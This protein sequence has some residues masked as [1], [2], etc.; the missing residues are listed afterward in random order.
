MT[1]ILNMKQ[2]YPATTYDIDNMVDQIEYMTG[3][4]FEDLMNVWKGEV[5]QRRANKK[6]GEDSKDNIVSGDAV[7]LSNNKA[8]R[9]GFSRNKRK[10]I[11]LQEGNDWM[12]TPM[13]NSK[14]EVIEYESAMLQAGNP[15][16]MLFALP[17]IMATLENLQ[18]EKW[19]IDNGF[20]VKQS[21]IRDMEKEVMRQGGFSKFHEAQHYQFQ[22]YVNQWFLA[23]F[24]ADP[25]N[26][27][28]RGVDILTNPGGTLGLSHDLGTP[29][30]RFSYIMEFPKFFM[31]V[32]EELMSDPFYQDN[33]FL[34]KAELNP[35]KGIDFLMLREGRSASNAEVSQQ[36]I[37]FGKLPDHIIR[38]IELYSIIKDGFNYSKNGFFK[39]LGTGVFRQYSSFMDKTMNKIIAPHSDERNAFELDMRN[40]FL[41][42]IRTMPVQKGR[43]LLKRQNRGG[44]DPEWYIQKKK[45]GFQFMDVAVQNDEGVD[46][47]YRYWF[48]R[49][50]NPFRPGYDYKKEMFAKDQERDKKRRAQTSNQ[51]VYHNITLNEHFD[52]I[53]ARRNN[54]QSWLYLN[55]RFK[56][57][58]AVG[59]LIFFPNGMAG[60]VVW[61]ERNEVAYVINENES[62]NMTYVESDELP[63]TNRDAR[64]SFNRKAN[65]KA[66]TVMMGSVIERLQRK[67]PEVKVER[68]SNAWFNSKGKDNAF[69]FLGTDGTI[70]INKSK[71]DAQ[72]Y[73]HEYAHIWNIVLR[74]RNPE[75]YAELVSELYGSPIYNEVLKAYPN[76]KG[77]RFDD[78]LVANFIQMRFVDM[79]AMMQGKENDKYIPLL[80]RA[81][82]E[83]VSFIKEML[84]IR[85]PSVMD[86]RS[87]YS[88]RAID[89]GD[90]YLQDM[91]SGSAPMN[92]ISSDFL[93]RVMPNELD[94]RLDFENF[95]MT[96]LRGLMEKSHSDDPQAMLKDNIVRRIVNTAVTRG[97]KVYKTAD[98]YEFDIDY[99][100]IKNTKKGT[101][102]EK[103]RLALEELERNIREE[104]LPVEMK[105]RHTV[106]NE[107]VD[108]L[109]G[110][111]TPELAS[112]TI[113]KNEEMDSFT[114]EKL[115]KTLQFQSGLKGGVDQAFKI[116]D[117]PPEYG[118]GLSPYLHHD[119][120]VII[121]N[122]N[123]PNSAKSISVLSVEGT[124][125]NVRPTTQKIKLDELIGIEADNI[126]LT[127]AKGDID[128]FFNTMIAATI[129]HHNKDLAVNNVGYLG[130]YK[131][132]YRPYFRMMSD[133][134]PQVKEIMRSESIYGLLH[135]NILDVVDSNNTWDIDRYNQD[136]IKSL[137]AL[138][139]N[140]KQYA[141]E[142]NDMPNRN[143]FI[144]ME[145]ALENYQKDS[146][147]D[148][149]R[150]KLRS[151]II[152]RKAFLEKNS[153]PEGGPMQWLDMEYQILNEA[154]YFMERVAT[155]QTNQ[156]S[157]LSGLG[158][159]VKTADRL[160]NDVTAHV[161]RVIKKTMF[162]I[163]E[164]LFKLNQEHKKWYKKYR[165]H[166][167]E[168]ENTGM[169]AKSKEYLRNPSDFLFD[170]LMIK[171][172]AVDKDGKTHDENGEA[173][174]VNT[175]EIHW[176]VKNARTAKA[177]ASGAITK[178]M[179]E[180]GKNVM[181]A[182]EKLMIENLMFKNST[183]EKTA[184]QQLDM[185]WNKGELPVMP[186]SLSEAL[187]KGDFSRIFSSMVRRFAH[188]GAIFQENFEGEQEMNEALSNTFFNQFRDSRMMGGASRFRKMGLNVY[189]GKD[190]KR[191]IVVD[192]MEKNKSMSKDIEGMYLFFAAAT[193]RSKEL[194]Q[195][196]LPTV[197]N[198]RAIL[199][200]SQLRSGVDMSNWIVWLND[201]ADRVIRG[202]TKK[203][204]GKHK[205]LG[206]EVNIDSL[207][208]GVVTATGAMRM[209]YNIPVAITNF[210]YNTGK[211]F[212]TAMTNA[213]LKSDYFGPKELA[214]AMIDLRTNN[215]KANALAWHLQV[216]NMSENDILS[217]R[218]H[219]NTEKQIFKSSQFHYL[220]FMADHTT[221][222][223]AMIA[224]MRKDGTWNAYTFD[225]ETGMLVYHP[226]KDLRYYDENGK[227][228]EEKEPIRKKIWKEMVREGA[229]DAK[230]DEL[231]RA[232]DFATARSMKAFVDIYIIGGMDKQTAAMAQDYGLGRALTQFKTYMYQ[233]GQNYLASR[234][235]NDDL[236]KWTMNEKGEVVWTRPEMEGILNTLIDITKTIKEHKR[237]NLEDFENLT[238]HQK[239]NLIQLAVDL[240]AFIIITKSLSLLRGPD[241]E[242]KKKKREQ[243]F[244]EF[245]NRWSKTL[246]YATFDLLQDAFPIYWAKEQLSAGSLMPIV[247]Q[248]DNVVSLLT[249]DL[250][251][252]IS[253]LEFVR[254]PKGALK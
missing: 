89:L 198:A 129:M 201:Y 151:A 37:D 209:G 164:R 186:E 113:N 210:T 32:K 145:T 78:E 30:G 117:L 64:L 92:E 146:E 124:S 105:N 149:Y 15:I 162:Y 70:Y 148:S 147:N 7:A 19:I 191:V 154:Q 237:F 42:A 246:E 43:E 5:A 40:N 60:T 133:M 168:F 206:V 31:K 83:I 34:Q 208:D 251:G 212:T 245:E 153:F 29:W 68:K 57:D 156:L 190:G 97:R 136:I 202:K 76:E 218:N 203:T 121:H 2:E 230:V 56:V 22:E 96:D 27:G 73:V 114:L 185:I 169:F 152:R 58:M 197:N 1:R 248:M 127:N 142:N 137:M 163:Q 106:S 138:T 213:L 247:G 214:A 222:V 229:Q 50:V 17:D 216:S 119:A 87:M 41:P 143:F 35:R 231:Q 166:V 189:I 254:V 122:Y 71:A 249:T 103:Q 108:W 199:H 95:S 4:P 98:G 242:S 226:T 112:L 179:V 3:L 227:K 159:F 52:Q 220:N 39:M 53:N 236:G 135:G 59:D 253:E 26:A 228:L 28:M 195:K 217:H 36:R 233:K 12:V 200:A 24:F 128:S 140:M 23:H 72:H 182:I 205:I 223:A 215:K 90:I 167:Y 77:Q 20:S 107:L 160:N 244:F 157:E 204:F 65:K 99:A 101:D 86:N 66:A 173:Y 48:S 243:G 63:D 134:I 47:Y 21:F 174:I 211:S 84:G 75:F 235:Y 85:G 192:N 188:E 177:L 175:N 6:S 225:N 10:A 172:S 126:N 14:G 224:Q 9:L 232:Y 51:W 240:G 221:R 80:Q 219:R 44:E 155:D 109:N 55:F 81:W 250:V 25:D 74:Q 131:F 118:V 33:V 110:G 132:S 144:E 171:E 115:V 104:I 180:Y 11:T 79:N 91:L 94:A 184:R 193:I 54:P 123:R 93:A 181:D 194:T 61:S 158:Y 234:Y 187:V 67:F 16:A 13:M 46:T 239:R 62:A 178:E 241:D 69:A 207:N 45:N 176:D 183:D 116:K 88:V 18:M 111:H 82:K 165:E 38:H 141:S 130:L 150:D 102:S 49:L 238:F 125:P 161:T 120:I 100:A 8:K 139:E 170:R 196:A 252:D